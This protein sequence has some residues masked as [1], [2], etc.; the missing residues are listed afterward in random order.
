MDEYEATGSQ[1]I[2]KICNL[3]QNTLSFTNDPMAAK[4][5]GPDKKEAPSPNRTKGERIALGLGATFLILHA[6]VAIRT[7]STI[8]KSA[9]NEVVGVEFFNDASM[10]IEAMLSDAELIKKLREG[11]VQVGLEFEGKKVAYGSGFIL[12]PNTLVTAAHCLRENNGQMYRIKIVKT[13]HVDGEK[14]S[15]QDV[16]DADENKT[17]GYQVVIDDEKDLGMVVFEKPIF[18]QKQALDIANNE[19]QT[20]NH[21]QIQRML[22]SAIR[23]VTDGESMQRYLKVHHKEYL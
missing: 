20:M 9:I 11:T 7:Y 2:D 23:S 3:E 19:P 17:S 14:R 1:E 12:N 10:Q 13:I 4:E 6:A 22:L 15:I 16:F 21:K 5:N 18:E 8:I